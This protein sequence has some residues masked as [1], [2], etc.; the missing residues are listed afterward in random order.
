[1][2][3]VVRIR[4]RRPE[5]HVGLARTLEEPRLGVAVVAADDEGSGVEPLSPPGEVAVDAVSH[6]TQRSVA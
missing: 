5:P 1:M 2:H 4:L 6:H 3:R